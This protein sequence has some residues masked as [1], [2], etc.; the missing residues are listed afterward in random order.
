[1]YKIADQVIKF[2]EETKK[3]RRVE[4]I[5]IDKIS[6]KVKIES[7]ILQGEALLPL[8]FVITNTLW[9]GFVEYADCTS[10]EEYDPP[11]RAICWPLVATRRLLRR[12]PGV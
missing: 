12:D 4:L 11:N 8:L 9:A 10:V 1:M 2:I 6:T 5:A 3:N 7:G